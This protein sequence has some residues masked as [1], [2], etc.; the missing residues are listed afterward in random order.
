M[1]KIAR[2]RKKIKELRK[3]LEDHNYYLDN[4]EQALGYGLALG[5]IEK[6]LDTLSEEP[7][8]SLEEEIRKYLSDRWKFG[9]C[10][11]VTPVVLPN[12]T[13]VDLKKCA[14]HFAQWQKEQMLK[15]VRTMKEQVGIGLNAY[16]M[17]EENG[18]AETLNKLIEK[19]ESL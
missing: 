18:K 16:D 19:I 9:C 8:K 6:F 15:E 7:D 3:L 12:Y 4:S 13:T 17:G 2:I 1:D 10:T 5:D 11:P 14:N